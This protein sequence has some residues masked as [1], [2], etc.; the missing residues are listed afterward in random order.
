MHLDVLA[1]TTAV[2]VPERLGVT[3]RFQQRIGLKSRQ[4][5]LMKMRENEWEGN[6][7]YLRIDASYG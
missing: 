3:K 2:D 6:I 7:S 5:L 1:K 4:N